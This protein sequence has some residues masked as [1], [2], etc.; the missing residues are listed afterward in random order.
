MMK[1][2]IR[3]LSFILIVLLLL[4]VTGFAREKTMTIGK[5][6]WLTEQN[7][8]EE[9]GA[10]SGKEKKPVLVVFSATWCK[11]CQEVKKTV[12]AKDEFKKV[13]DKAVLLYIEQT[14][15]KGMEYVK[16]Y[17]VKA[18]PT[19]TV[20]NKEG[21]VVDTGEPERTVKGFLT[22]VEEVEKGNTRLAYEKRLKKN[23]GDREALLKLAGKFGFFETQKK[24]EYLEK[25]IGK[26]PDYSDPLTKMAC[27]QIIQV[28]PITL[29]RKSG[30]E[31]EEF[32]QKCDK[33]VMAIFAAYLPD[34]FEGKLKGPAGYAALMNWHITLDRPVK[35]FE[36]YQNY[37]KGKTFADIL[38]EGGW[39]YSTATKALLELEKVPEALEIYKKLKSYF[40][41][42]LE[43]ADDNLLFNIFSISDGITEYYLKKNETDKA[44]E[45]F[46]ALLKQI[47]QWEKAGKISGRVN[48]YVDFILTRYANKHDIFREEVLKRLDKRL[49]TNK[50]IDAVVF[51]LKKAMLLHKSG[52]KEEAKAVILGYAGNESYISSIKDTFKPEVFNSFAWTLHELGLADEKALKIAEK[53]VA[54]KK[55]DNNLDTLACIHADLGNYK[56]AIEIEEEAVKLT[57]SKKSKKEFQERLDKWKEK[58]KE[59]EK[60][61]LP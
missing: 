27:E 52:K 55:K 24:I 11:P 60:K 6:T 3:Q 48:Q 14:D 37:M 57:K 7:S 20:I 12:F 15:P 35:A 45:I 38:P 25:V 51:I 41:K 8:L 13:A 39:F 58:A 33:K 21:V 54:L 10:M 31:K 26:T 42:N 1:S 9:V 40:V 28:Y 29:Y 5:C 18:F 53:S 46:A 44:K 32:L 50:G 22:W 59:A 36:V 43:K 4:G 23:S 17:N 30:K 56:K 19:F 61:Q 49:E 2:R 47:E 16:K 34:K